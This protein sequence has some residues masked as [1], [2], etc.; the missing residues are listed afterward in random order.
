MSS[1]KLSLLKYFTRG[2]DEMQSENDMLFHKKNAMFII[3]KNRRRS[4]RKENLQR[5]GESNKVR[6]DDGGDPS[7]LLFQNSR[8]AQEGD[9]SRER[10]VFAHGK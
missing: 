6:R 5:V 4:V 3:W 9:G 8:T 2:T 10:A 7:A 1:V